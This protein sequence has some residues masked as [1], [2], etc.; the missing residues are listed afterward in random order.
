MRSWFNQFLVERSLREDIA[1]L[2]LDIVVARERE[3]EA[4]ARAV[5]LEKTVKLAVNSLR[6][7]DKSPEQLVADLKE[8]L[9]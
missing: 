7:R 5:K 6:E 8:G 9:K 2:K 1:R 4:R 3:L